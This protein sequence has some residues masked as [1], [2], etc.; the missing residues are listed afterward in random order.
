MR[1]HIS[2]KRDQDD[3]D[4]NIQDKDV[5]DS[6]DNPDFG[7][8]ESIQ[9]VNEDKRDFSDN[10]QDILADPVK[11]YL[12]EMGMK[13]LL[14]KAGEVSIAK[15]IEKG[16]NIII[17]ALL[18]SRLI[19]KKLESLDKSREDSP[20]KLFRFIDFA[21]DIAEG[22]LEKRMGEIFAD[23]RMIQDVSSRLE[24][25]P[26][27]EKYAVVRKELKNR[28]REIINE[29]N[30][31]PSQIEN[32]I[33]E[34]R[35]RYRILVK[36]KIKRKEFLFRLK[37][38]KEER[39]RIHLNK[40]IS[41]LDRIMKDHQQEIGL[42]IHEI[43]KALQKISQGEKIREQAKKELIESNLRL[44]VSLAKRYTGRG[45]QF[46][47]LIQE[48]NLGLMRAVEKY[49]YRKGFKFSTYATWW[50][51]QAITRFIAD[52]A[53]TIR[54][55]VHMVETINKL[56][57]ITKE[58]VKEVG[59]E[60]TP[61]DLGKK[62]DLP[63][64]K[65]RTIIKIAQEP[66]SLNAPVG[67]ENDSFLSDFIEDT[68]FPSPPDLVIHVKMK[69][70]IGQA[71]GFLTHREAEVLRMRF[72]LGDG[73]EHTLEEVGQR[74]RVTRERIRQIE[75]KALRNLKNSNRARNLRAFTSQY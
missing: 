20:D 64:N 57:K 8:G 3:P 11:I 27:L 59:R 73:N 16:E 51:R 39:S 17:D 31:H 6:P 18:E 60:P 34:L 48:G 37:K 43:R 61:E 55:P 47:D 40:K 41:V 25:I 30:I 44:V 7:K 67:K 68:I 21:E 4:L 65:V 14:D 38:Y 54:I 72:G 1:L 62:M 74:F 69:E 19:Q 24:K 42:D 58:L 50:I 36:M 53:R 52:H 70:Q 63:A 46:L 22:N 26:P 23:I 29:L 5:L 45:V 13:S 49:D 28:L 32:L 75:A 35:E 71:L 66:V 10:E 12:R 33:E 15:K 9:S 56:N 2:V